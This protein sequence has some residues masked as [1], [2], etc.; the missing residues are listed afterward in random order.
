M[1]RE[2]WHKEIIYQIYPKS[3]LDTSQN[4]YGDLQ[5]IIK[6]IDYLKELGI[7][8]IW[9]SPVF[10]SPM[11][12]NG[13]DISDYR[14]IDPIFGTNEDM[15][16]LIQKAK[17]LGIK[18]MLD[19]VVN[20]TSDQHHWFKEAL[21]GKDNKYRDYYIWRDKKNTLK[22]VFLGDAW[23]YDKK[24][25]Q[26]YFHLFAKE[27]P[28]LNW[29]NKAVRDDIYKMMNFWIEKGVE[30][31][32]MDVIEF[33]GK[34]PD[35]YIIADGEKLHEYIREMNLNTF[36]PKNCITV[37][38]SWSAT[39]KTADL[40]TNPKRDELSMIFRFDHIT[41]FWDNQLGKWNSSDFD[42]KKFK[43]IIFERQKHSDLHVWNTLFW[44]SHDLPRSA[45]H[46]ISD[47]Y[48]EY[49]AKML[50]G[51]TM[52]MSGTP[53]IY[54]GE[55]IGMTNI[56]LDED[57]YQD[58][59]AKMALKMLIKNGYDKKSALKMVNKMSRDNARTPM[60]WNNKQ[61]AGFSVVTPWIKVNPNYNKINV[62]EQKL[63]KNSVLNF[64]KSLIE[65]RKSE[66][67]NELILYGEFSSYLNESNE[68]FMYERKLNDKS[69]FVIANF[70]DKE[71]RISPKYLSGDIVISNYP[72]SLVKEQLEPYQIIITK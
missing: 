34:Q 43:N 55:E 8:C 68:I 51:I 49:G 70:S 19:L 47:K 12:D 22:S 37:G 1:K 29:E 60:Q 16:V 25:K 32:R 46:Y 21:K 57:E 36:G 15:Y 5:G 40:Y 67:L 39:D 2:E 3:F 31:F 30:G 4:G 23:E 11:K 14:Q 66:E 52:F 56:L 20:H 72:N 50:A 58:I 18:I 24:S 7:T 42:L 45:S 59:E 13:Y 33:L 44:G 64:Y 27:Q 9:I 17:E 38:E 6:K 71:V 48:T 35:N 53:F 41:S 26:Y 10:K 62:Q 54:Q 65:L 69:I 28:D 61:N 63:N